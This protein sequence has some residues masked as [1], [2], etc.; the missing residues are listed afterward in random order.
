MGNYLNSADALIAYTKVYKSP[1]FIDKSEVLNEIIPRIGT[2]ENCICLTRPRRF[3]KSIMANMIAAFLSVGFDSRDIFGNLKIADSPFYTEHLNQHLVIS[4]SFNRLPRRCNSFE[5]YISRI[6]QKLL[7]DLA[8]LYPQVT[9]DPEDAVWDAL[10]AVYQAEPE[11][12]FIFILD[13]WDFIFHRHFVTEED[14]IEYIDFLSNLL[15]DQPYVALAYMTGIL[16]IAKYS[17]G[18]ELNMFLE[19]T[20][21][22]EEMFGNA[23]GFTEAEV[24]V[25]FNRFLARQKNPG[26][27]RED[28]K[29]WYDG[30][31]VKSGENI[32]NPRS[33]V[34]ALTNNNL[35]NYWTSS[36]PYDEIYYY[37][38]HNT[39]AVRDDIARMVSGIPVQ[40]NIR[41]YA[42]TSMNLVS[43]NEI[44]SAMTVYGFL[45]FQK[46]CVRIPNR[47]LMERF[48]EML[49]EEPSLGYVYQL[50]Q[51]SEKMLRA[52]LDGNTETML[53]I[54]EFAHDTEIPLLSYNNETD[55]T[56]LVNLV[57]LAARDSYRIERED[58]A[59]IGF[60][61]FIFYPEI[62]RRADGIILELKVNHTADEAI[63]QIKD[64]KYVFKFDGKLGEQPKY[65]GRVLGVG[66]AYDK[67]TKAHECRIEVLREAL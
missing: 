36:G 9:I 55:L 27:T 66:I 34:A 26:I 57:Y 49:R 52:T 38:S 56:A 20:M 51:E 62:D 46:G 22:S 6:E 1:Y 10:K 4:I 16:P 3:G 64:K 50:A 28:L 19:Y 14:K 35:G 7:E 21:A 42:A 5:Q 2:T 48:D 39:D 63:R 31:S 23:F 43:R 61:D 40:A 15:K 25:L 32:Y 59:G 65:T 58:K 11:T 30:Y 54:L 33:I 53:R 17:S 37:I 24:D 29:T 41:E 45:S 8:E 12:R 67:K 47:E 60:V 13:E 18:S 44:F